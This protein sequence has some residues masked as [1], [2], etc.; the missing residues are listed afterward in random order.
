VKLTAAA[1]ASE[2][3]RF[4]GRRHIPKPR[5]A[6]CSS[7]VHAMQ[8]WRNLEDEK[9]LWKHALFDSKRGLLYEHW[10]AR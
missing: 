1:G 4:C 2:K 3:G 10:L 6:Q 8:S 7:Y 9:A 5:T